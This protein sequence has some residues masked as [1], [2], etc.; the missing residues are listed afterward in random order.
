[1]TGPRS[2]LAAMTLLG[3]IE[4]VKFRTADISHT[5]QF[6]FSILF[7]QIQVVNNYT[8]VVKTDPFNTSQKLKVLKLL[9]EA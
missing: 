4:P 8:F 1:M 2:I 3:P 7:R 9:E 5:A 6:C